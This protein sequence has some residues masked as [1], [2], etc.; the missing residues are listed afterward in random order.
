LVESFA[1]VDDDGDV[2]V[3][4]ILHVGFG[5]WGWFWFLVLVLVFGF[6]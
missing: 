3:L 1:C 4:G 2:G 5:F 6:V